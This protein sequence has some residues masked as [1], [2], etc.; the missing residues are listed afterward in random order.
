MRE[1]GLRLSADP[2]KFSQ[3]VSNLLQNAFRYTPPGGTLVI[4]AER[5]PE[6]MVFAF[7]NTRGELEDQDLPFIFE[8]FY[9]GEKSRS[10]EYG[11]SGIGLVIVKELVEAHGGARGRRVGTGLCPHLVLAARDAEVKTVFTDSL[12]FLSTLFTGGG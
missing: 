6:E 7:A 5:T 3:V 1:R 11:G 10:R 2:E 4:S 8:R 12:H 9:R